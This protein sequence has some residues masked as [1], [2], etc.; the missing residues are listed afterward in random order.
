M[1]KRGIPKRVTLPNSRTFL[2]RYKR[3]TRAHLP[4]NI[5][6]ARPYKQRG[7]PKG[8]RRPL[9]VAAAPTAQQGQGIGDI[10]RFAKK[11]VKRKVARN[12]GKMA[13]EQ[14]PG[15]VEKLSGN[16]KNRRLK[17]ILGS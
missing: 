9:R 3:T 14:L 4:A 10:F 5:H 1:V 16:V 13:L 2:A 6:L 7:A 12:F 15:V 11:V 8:K 17:T